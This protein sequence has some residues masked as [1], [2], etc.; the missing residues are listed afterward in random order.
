MSR[1]DKG[2]ILD[3]VMVTTGMGRSTARRM[4]TGPK[5][6]HPRDQADKR[7]LKPRG[8]SYDSRALLE[9]VWALMG[10]PCGK[11]LVVMLPLWLPL[12]SDA[13]DLDR[14]FATEDA[15]AELPA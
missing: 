10:L 2:A 8:Y 12:L 5:L 9:H 7:S 6:P 11:Y 4:L 1:A 13:G 3:R 15:R 14:P